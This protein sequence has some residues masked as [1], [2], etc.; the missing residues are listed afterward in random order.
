MYKGLI[1]FFLPTIAFS[2]G[3][4]N[5][6]FQADAYG[7]ESTWEI[8]MVGSDSVYA[9]AGPFV[10]ASYN[11]QLVGL[12]VGEYNLVV[13][14]QF[15]DGICCE[16]GEGWFGIENTCGV[17]AFVY[18]FAQ[19]QITIPFEVLPCPPPLVDCM[20]PEANNYN[21]EAYF[22]GEN[23]Q[24]DVTFRL[25]LNGP[26]PP[27]I[28]IPEVN[29][30]WNAW[31]GSCSQMTDD[32]GDG[33]WELTASI[34]QGSYLW[35]FSA[36]EW[37]VQELPVG[38]SESPC[39]LFDEFGYVN[40]NLVVDGPVSLPPCCWESCL[41]C[42]AVP[43]CVNPNASNWNPWANFD[44]GSC[45]GL[46]AEC[47]PWQTEIVT[48]LILDNY[49]SETSFTIQNVTS[50]ELVIDLSVGQLSDD[51]VGVPLM[52]ATC[53]T[54]GDELEI[55]VNDSYGD[56]LGAS[57]WGGQDGYV[58]VEACG[59]TLWSLPVADFG[60]SVSSQFA[61]PLCLDVEDVVGCGD[62][63]YV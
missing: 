53:A 58:M 34:T 26:H 55:V 42:G 48:T 30:T 28:D 10:N 57:Q 7:G 45:T 8:Y 46:G 31:C 2:Q 17:S 23:C 60:Y 11:E 16:F 21:P 43:G 12:P 9:S 24:Y 51:I 39:F 5:V 59:D 44:N 15:G 29:G 22:D 49:P 54:T 38:V 41:P 61:A 25:D 47:E 52:F 50:D 33:V 19:A 3:W 63:D 18:D 13:S 4:V 40:R 37:E 62:P 35:K 36:D 27:E 1:L 20:D 6:E 56:G 32:D 14:D